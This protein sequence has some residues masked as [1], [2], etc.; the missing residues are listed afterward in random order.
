MENPL[1]F[2]QS[3]GA[4]ELG[5]SPIDAVAVL[6][7]SFVLTTLIGWV[8]RATHTGKHY[9]QSYVQTL[10]I[11]GTVVSLTILIIGSNVA[12]AFAMVGA[13]SIVRFRNSMKETRDL[14]FI[15]MSMSIGMAVGVQAYGL[16][17]FSALAL[18]LLVFTMHSFTFFRRRHPAFRLHVRLP[19]ELNPESV[20]QSTFDQLLRSHRL[21]SL[22]T[23]RAGV[24]Q[25]AC[26]DVVLKPEASAQDLIESVQQFNG[27]QKIVLFLA[28]DIDDLLNNEK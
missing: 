10:V 15:F 28:T 26:Y 23:V 5:F 12:R 22:E 7:L 20:F 21:L 1:S 13:L 3:P 4:S 16:A 2:L 25:E 6:G 17:I 27:N 18:C 11:M 9:S 24:L 14:G 19:L 8:Y